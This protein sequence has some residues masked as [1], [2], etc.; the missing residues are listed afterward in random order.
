MEDIRKTA[1][2]RELA[3]TGIS[4]V[5]ALICAGRIF[6]LLL[7]EG[8][9]YTMGIFPMALL[10]GLY[11]LWNKALFSEE[12]FFSARVRL[13]LAVGFTA[14]QTLGLF[15]SHPQI[16]GVLEAVIWTICFTP[17]TYAGE[18]MLFAMVKRRVQRGGGL[19]EGIPEEAFGREETRGSFWRAFAV[20]FGGFCI[21]FATYYPAIMAYDVIPQLDQIRVS[22]LTTHHPLIHTLYLAA[23]L[24]LGEILPFFTNA[25]RAGLAIYSLTQMA[26]MAACFSYAYV[27]MV[28]HGVKRWIC[29]LFVV[30]TAFF[31]T[32]GMLAVSITKDTVY[33]ALVMVF[34]L[35][36][37]EF[38]IR[39]EYPGG[40]FPAVYLLVTLLLLLFRNNSV[41]AWI[42]YVIF[43]AFAGRKRPL[44]FRRCCAFHGAVFLLYL[45]VNTLLIHAASATSDTYARETLS[46]PAQQIAR[47][48]AY[49]KE[50][51]TNEDLAALGTIWKEGL[52]EYEPAIADRSKRDITGEEDELKILANEW[53]SLGLR[54]PGEYLKAFLLKN[55][56]VWDMTDVSYL[57]LYSYSKGYLQITYPSNQQEYMEVLAPGYV[58]HQKLRFLQAV[59]RFFAAG[60]ELWRYCPP[61]A[62]VMQPALYSYLLLFYCL[63]CI[64]WK[65]TT[66]L[67]PAGF[68][69]AL[70]V[71]ILLGPCVLIRY[72]YP[73]ILSV[74]VL[75]LLLFGRDM[76]EAASQRGVS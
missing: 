56:G 9:V 44:F 65:R 69:F 31:P 39:E 27:F 24:K 14:L 13:M 21:P 2:V 23:C 47:V 74:T 25:D 16:A 76:T 35:L 57:D 58:R 64:A 12:V 33:A 5:L 62:F 17:L 32:H 46:V 75:T 60:Y 36:V 18:N 19:P 4:A 51:L 73:L 53:I 70:M 15:W 43:A 48:A 50:E 54:Y 68:L 29:R 3:F 38:S 49:H 59:Y 41:Y 71:T 55:K 8:H 63:C 10:F 42:I 11:C 52:P 22:G 7:R 40:R 45:F 67:L 61:M 72:Y 30:C 66:M 28:R 20:I 1:S 26:F 34:T 6:L 37:W